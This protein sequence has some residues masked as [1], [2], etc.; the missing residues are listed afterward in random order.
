[1]NKKVINEFRGKY[2]FL[3]NYYS[4]P[5][6][7]KGLTFKNNEA[8][9]HAQKTFDPETKIKFTELDPSTAKK[10][11]RQVNL[12][13]DWEQVKYFIMYD[14]CRE[15]FIQN[16]D[17]AEKL[18]ATGDAYLEEGN[19]WNDTTWGTCGGKG[20]NWLGRILMLIRS[21]LNDKHR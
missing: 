16:P 7:Y 11:G 20:D 21:E 9:F 6:T 3:S 17:L 5:V 13:P 2:Y 15:K 12:R 19:D 8:T 4:A 1:M 14:I 18:L 10:L